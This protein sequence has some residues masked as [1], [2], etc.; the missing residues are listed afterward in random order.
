MKSIKC[1]VSDFFIFI[2]VCLTRKNKRRNKATHKSR[3]LIRA[4]YLQPLLCDNFYSSLSMR[5]HFGVDMT[6]NE[7]LYVNHN[8]QLMNKIKLIA[9]KSSTSMREI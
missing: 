2:V 8:L 9:Q 7:N 4:T 1:D 5:R 6:K 3:E